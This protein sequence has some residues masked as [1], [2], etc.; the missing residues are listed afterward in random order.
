MSDGAARVHTH[1]PQNRFG[2]GAPNAGGDIHARW[3]NIAGFGKLQTGEGVEHGG[4]PG[5]GSAR[6]RGN[7]EPHPR[8]EPLLHARQFAAGALGGERIGAIARDLDCFPD[9]AREVRYRRVLAGLSRA[10]CLSRALFLLFFPHDSPLSPAL[11][12]PRDRRAG[13]GASRRQTA[14]TC[15]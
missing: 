7:G 13:A 15:A 5:A 8:I 11:H 2:L 4:F 10:E 9:R 6:E 1:H 14:K 3:P 12:S